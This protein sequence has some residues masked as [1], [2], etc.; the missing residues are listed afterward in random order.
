M[1]G[2]D[3]RMGRVATFYSWKGGVGR[4]FALANVA[5]QLARVGRNVLMIDWDLEAPG[6]D[7]YFRV[8]ADGSGKDESQSVLTLNE[9]EPGCGLFG[10]LDSAIRAGDGRCVPDRTGRRAI[11]TI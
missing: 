5:V 10:L 9:A 1:S 6:L 8:S 2:A 11:D 4:T 7:R 3:G